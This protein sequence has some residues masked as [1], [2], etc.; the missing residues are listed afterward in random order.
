[1]AMVLPD[2]TIGASSLVVGGFVVMALLLALAFVL[3]IGAARP[4]S[5]RSE[6]TRRW[7]LLATLGA[8][9]WLKGTWLLAW[10]GVL[11]RFDM[12]PPPFGLLVVTI[13][14]LGVVLAFSRVGTRLLR[15]WSFAAL[16]GI[17][18]FR[19][20]LELLMHRAYEDGVMPIQMSYS[21]RNFDILTGISAAVLGLALTR[22]TVPRWIVMA[23]NVGGLALLVN[24][25]TVAVLGTPVIRAFGDEYLNTWIAY[26]PFVWLPAVM[27]LVAWA[28]H[29]IVFR[30]LA[31]R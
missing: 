11:R 13:T 8:V 24:V 17:H 7:L 25:V 4:G 28:G 18:A 21:G 16:V 2:P 22:W 26:P 29:L 14:A 6:T 30:K 5:E 19:F 27:V 15:G 10:S 9:V 20:P 1:M 23:W 3:A 31:A 12:V